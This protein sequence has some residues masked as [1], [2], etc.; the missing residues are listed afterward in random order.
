[1]KIRNTTQPA[2]RRTHSHAVLWLM[3]LTG[4]AR[5][6]LATSGD[7]PIESPVHR[8]TNS[9][10]AIRRDLQ[11]VTS[12]LHALLARYGLAVTAE[13]SDSSLVSIEMAGVLPD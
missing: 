9:A 11:L 10:V 8:D 3:M 5:I 2:I 13:A 6:A 7:L 12:S 1:M 4:F